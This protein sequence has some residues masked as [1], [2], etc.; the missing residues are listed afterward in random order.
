MLFPID[1]H[2]HHLKKKKKT[3]SK[4]CFNSLGNAF[5]FSITVCILK[6]QSRQ[7]IK[8]KNYLWTE[9]LTQ[10]FR[11]KL[12]QL[13]NLYI[14]Y[15]VKSIKTES[16]EIRKKPIFVRFSCL[17]EIKMLSVE[18]KNIQKF[19]A[20]SVFLLLLLLFFGRKG[21]CTIHSITCSIWSK[22]ICNF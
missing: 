6:T 4:L 15:T 12:C 21:A 16:L 10:K 18:K 2:P 8:L 7:T 22:Y 17:L 19:T 14:L 11:M 13:L 3:Y 9:M 5:S 1:W 20:A